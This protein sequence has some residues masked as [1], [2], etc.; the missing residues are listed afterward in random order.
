MRARCGLEWEG[1]RGWEGAPGWGGQLAPAACTAAGAG[2]C[3]TQAACAPGPASVEAR[4][5]SP[6]AYQSWTCEERVEERARLTREV[7]RVSSLQRENA[8]A[9]TAMMAVGL[10]VFWP[11]PQ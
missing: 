7:Q 9:D 10:F 11:M 5:V 6:D 1:D 3:A 2:A 8:T 4:Y